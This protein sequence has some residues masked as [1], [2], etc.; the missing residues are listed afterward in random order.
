Q[1]AALKDYLLDPAKHYSWN[2]MPNFRLSDVEATNLAAF[3]LSVKG[4]TLDSAATGGDAA[5]GKP[6]VQSAGCLNC[7]T[8][9]KS[10]EN[11]AKT[12][13]LGAIPTD[14]WS[15]GCTAADPAARKNVP[16]FGFS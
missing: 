5:R 14:H 11:S 8:V 4:A 12:P 10:L 13:D 16:D 2:P 3:L 9:D 7:H 6:L 15:E 1:P